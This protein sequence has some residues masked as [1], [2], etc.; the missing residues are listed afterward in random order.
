M[1]ARHRSATVIAGALTAALA[2]TANLAPQA[3]AQA[4]GVECGR[5][6]GVG[7]YCGYYKG[8]Q[9]TDSG[10]RGRHVN[11][12]QALI[13]QTAHY[14]GR[15]VVDGQFGPDTVRAVKWYQKKKLGAGAADGKVGPRTWKK[16]RQL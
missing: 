11:E 16:L 6:A 1:N 8:Q 2:L 15:L 12:I 14:P 5:E 4:R 7:M 10:D 3:Q 9:Y 13:M